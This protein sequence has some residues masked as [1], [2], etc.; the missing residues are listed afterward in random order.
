MD[1]T[2]TGADGKPIAI[3]NASYSIHDNEV[4][5]YETIALA[6][7]NASKFQSTQRIAE[8]N[9]TTESMKSGF[10]LSLIHI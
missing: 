9:P 7:E 2:V 6:T 8:P 3:H 10:N 5:E 4:A 1:P